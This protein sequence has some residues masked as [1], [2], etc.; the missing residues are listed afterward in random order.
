VF[1]TADGKERTLKIE[2]WELGALYW[3]C[4]SNCANDEDQAVRKVQ[5]K[6]MALARTDIHLFL[7][8]T[9]HYHQIGA[10][11]PFIVIGVFYPSRDAQLP[12]FQ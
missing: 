9:L 8:T 12:L 1:E 7:G 2:D 10:P 6:Y 5:S 3:K 11:N 4:L